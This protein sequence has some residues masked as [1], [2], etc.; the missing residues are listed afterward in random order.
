MELKFRAVVID[1][2]GG[3]RLEY[4][5]WPSGDKA[6]VEHG[7]F[8][9]RYE[10]IQQYTGLKDKNGKEIYEGDIVKYYQ[11]YAKRYDTHIVKWDSLF[12]CF[13]LFEEGNEWAKE[14]DWVKITA[15]ENLGNVF[16]TPELI[17]RAVGV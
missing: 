11:P 7:G 16:E 12:A 6:F 1:D 15:L 5:I 4:K 8:W 3:K 17:P 2:D 9:M 14:S 13:S 10:T